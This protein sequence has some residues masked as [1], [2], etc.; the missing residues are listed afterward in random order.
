M[1]LEE[2]LEIIDN[3]ISNLEIHISIL[4]QD[5]DLNPGLDVDGKPTR[6]SILEQFNSNKQALVAQKELLTNQ[7]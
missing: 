7:G 3:K 4:S 5:I 1:N 2:K 6:A